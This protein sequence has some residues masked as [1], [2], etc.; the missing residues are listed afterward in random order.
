MPVGFAD[1]AIILWAMLDELRRS[2]PD[3]AQ[4]ISDR[5]DIPLDKVEQTAAVFRGYL[6]DLYDWLAGKL[7][8]LHRQVYKGKTAAQYAADADAS[9]FL[10]EEAQ[11]FVT[12]FD[13]DGD[14]LARHLTGPKVRDALESRAEAERLRR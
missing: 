3:A 10:Y 13:L 9:N 12:D 4:K 14:Y 1:D 8:E 7:P 2:F 11:A 6:G 5:F